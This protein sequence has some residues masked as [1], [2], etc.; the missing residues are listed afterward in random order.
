MTHTA[1]L[2]ARL[3]DLQ[4][5]SEATDY[6]AAASLQDLKT[7]GYRLADAMADMADALAEGAQ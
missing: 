2:A 3:R 6:A 5:R 1:T 4:A 7:A